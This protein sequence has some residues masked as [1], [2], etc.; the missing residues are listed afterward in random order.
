M[1]RVKP[2]AEEVKIEEL[3]QGLKIIYHGSE[4]ETFLLTNEGNEVLVS[5]MLKKR[6]EKKKRREI[7][8]NPQNLPLYIVGNTEEKIIERIEKE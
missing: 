4:I 6:L 2:I 8:K 3:F 1:E 7:L 5:E